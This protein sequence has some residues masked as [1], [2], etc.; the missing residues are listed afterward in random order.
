[1][2][3]TSIQTTIMSVVMMVATGL[4]VTLILVNAVFGTRAALDAAGDLVDETSAHIT[5]QVSELNDKARQFVAAAV[6]TD[7]IDNP[8]SFAVAHPA[9]DFM[10]AVLSTDP[11]YYSM[12]VGFENGDFYQ[13]ITL[14]RFPEAAAMLEAPEGAMWAEVRIA[15]RGPERQRETRFLNDQRVPIG[16]RSV[17]ETRFKPADRPWFSAAQA[18]LGT[19]KTTPYVYTSLGEPGVTFARPTPKGAVVGLDITLS[20]VSS[21]LDD[22]FITRSSTAFVFGRDGRLTGYPDL[23][24]MIGADEVTG[25]RRL[26]GLDDLGETERTFYAWAKDSNFQAKDTLWIGARPYLTVASP[27][28]V[29]EGFDEFVGVIVPVTEILLPYART[30][31]WAV[32]AS[33]AVF[34][35]FVPVTRLAARRISRPVNALVEET[36]KVGEFRFDEVT[37]VRTDIVE[38][39]ALSASM[40]QMAG[41]VRRYRDDVQK[42][43]DKLEQL[44]VTGISLASERSSTKLMRTI[45][46]AARSLSR[47]E[48]ALLY[49][50]DGD[51]LVLHTAIGR[52]FGEA[53]ENDTAPLPAPRRVRMAD[54]TGAPT[55]DVLSMATVWDMTIAVDDIYTEDEFDFP[56]AK[57]YDSDTDTRTVSVLTVPLRPSGRDAV[58]VLQLFNARS[59]MG[60][61][62]PFAEASVRFVESLAAQ[63][64]VSIDSRNLQDALQGLLDAMI[65]LLAGAIDAKSPYTGGH[66]ERVPELAKM[67]AHEAN[68]V[69][70]GPLAAFSFETDEEWREF[71]VAAWLHD[72]GKVTTPE[73]VVD[74]SVKLET[75]YNRIHEVRTRFEVLRRDAEI[76]CLKAQLAGADAAQA[77]AQLAQTIKDLEDDFA[78]IAELNMGG[79]FL[80]DD[81]LERLTAVA[82][83]TWTRTFDRTLGLSWEDMKRVEQAGVPATPAVESVLEDR[84]EHVIPREHG[85][86]IVGPGNPYGFTME[87]PEALYNQGE[88][89]N[90]SVRRGTLTAE[91]RF[92]INE[93]IIQTIVMLEHLPFPKTMARVPEIAGGHHETMIGTGYPKGL[94]ADDMTVPA[95][96]MAIADIFEALTAR[97]RPYKKAKTLSE[98]IRI[99]GFMLKD[100]H[101]DP[102]LFRLFLS[103]GV[104]KR[105]AERFLLPDQIDE[106]DVAA[107]LDA[108][109]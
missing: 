13:I 19:A 53:H 77:T 97:D 27:I 56:D 47:A 82:G 89:Y 78:F 72:C 39:N 34:A 28:S 18:A 76:A 106:V 3:T 32:L 33:L 25:Q 94:R 101:I 108:A 1:M 4:T 66:C 68:T 93:H 73:Y 2:R 12:F 63:A 11:V 107:Y 31:L 38:M 96:I 58:G 26:R 50:A 100:Q 99:M 37:M 91:E 81:K 90:L 40:V 87:V 10:M 104:Y 55:D 36:K 61:V 84:P 85:H 51:D 65:R 52:R 60:E 14:D 71:E 30:G 92:K 35:L 75:I 29:A 109:E 69:R 83:R 74:K 103:S 8:V 95:K 43:Q 9:R 98:S 21:A 6:A 80:D 64:A 105:Y 44:V 23:E 20:S 16:G 42:A 70:Q 48:G 57:T 49:V 7:G 62:E 67:L 17:P 5:T 46:E 79:E 22:I 45:L 86:E 54:A 24:T 41:A 88:V 59:E 15:G 102:D